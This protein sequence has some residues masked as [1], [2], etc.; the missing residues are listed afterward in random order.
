MRNY[1]GGPIPVDRIYWYASQIL[2]FP[3]DLCQVVSSVI[4]DMDVVYLEWTRKEQEKKR[5]S[6][7]PPK[8]GSSPAR[9]PPKRPA[10]RR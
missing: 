1:D 7:E 10:R 4:H 5:K 8:T 3:E 9:R 6:S 2:E